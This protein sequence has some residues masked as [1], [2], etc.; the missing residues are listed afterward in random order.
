MPDHHAG[1]GLR[2][3]AAKLNASFEKTIPTKF[4]YIANYLRHKADLGGFG[5]T[6][7]ITVEAKNGAIYDKDYLETLR[8]INDDVFLMPGVDRAYMKS[9]WTPSTQ[10]RGVTEEGFESGP[11]IPDDLRWLAGHDRTDSRATWS[12]RVKLARSWRRTAGRAWS[13]FHCCRPTWPPASRSI[14]AIFPGSL[15]AIRTKYSS[16]AGRD[17]HHR[18]RK[19]VRRPD[20]RTALVPDLLRDGHSDQRQLPSVLHPLLAGYLGGSH[21]LAGGGGVAAWD[22]WPR[23]ALCSIPIRFWCR[24]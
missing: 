6:V 1:A 10:W 23:W 3:H 2:G 5:N 22:C 11:V 16:D 7:R 19:S 14:T 18:L 8:K 13:S 21:L 17:S 9:L 20:R 4:P 24:S 15:E 12:A